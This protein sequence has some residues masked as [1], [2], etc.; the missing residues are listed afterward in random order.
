MS[1]CE[2]CGREYKMS[3]CEFCK[4]E[5][6]WKER[7]RKE[8]LNSLNLPS[9]LMDDLKRYNFPPD[10]IKKAINDWEECGNLYLTGDT[11]S[12][13]TLFACAVLIERAKL[14]YIENSFYTYDFVSVPDVL[15]RLRK[16]MINQ[17]EETESDI[18]EHLYNVDYLVLDDLG[19][20]KTSDWVLQELYL[21]IN[22]RYEWLKPTIF[23]SNLTLPELEEQFSD[24]R[25]PSRIDRMCKV[26]K[27]D[28]RKWVN[29]EQ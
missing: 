11:G 18:I 28:Y 2:K 4:R 8:F 23:T 20:E 14:D 26:V 5:R 7:V 27:V 12:G 22:H 21:I 25:I 24:R 13:K 9:R 19:A 3:I 17:D 15:R 1:I 10:K 29:D 16:A 6:I